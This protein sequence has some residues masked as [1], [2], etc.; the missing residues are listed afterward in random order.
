MGQ[1]LHG[2]A[3][4]TKQ[5]RSVQRYKIVKRA[6]GRCPSA[7]ASIRRRR[8]SGRNGPRPPTCPPGPGSHAPPFYPS[9]L[10]QLVAFRRHTLLAL[11]HL[12][13]ARDRGRQTRQESI[14]ERPDRL[15]PCRHRPSTDGRGHALSF[16]DHRSDLKVRAHPWTSG[17]VER[18]SRNLKEATVK[19]S[20]YDDHAQLRQ[21]LANVI[22]A[23]N[24]AP[25]PRRWKGLTPC[26]CICK[27]CGQP[28]PSGSGSIRA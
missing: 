19:R 18:M 27:Q 15:L 11:E 23:Y 6:S 2:S 4:M 12:A 16:R 25:R 5:R 13:A 9:R 20:H 28:S 8:P 22:D 7:M 14:Q 26:E 24:F 17:Q 10:R 21:H 1:V 3:T